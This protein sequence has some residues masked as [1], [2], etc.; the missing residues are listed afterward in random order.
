[1]S[2]ERKPS[3]RSMNMAQNSGNR[4]EGEGKILKCTYPEEDVIMGRWVGK[5]KGERWLEVV[6]ED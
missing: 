2:R 5:N 4:T 1:M 3:I 6:R